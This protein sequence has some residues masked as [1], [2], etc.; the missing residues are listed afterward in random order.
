MTDQPKADKH[1]MAPMSHTEPVAY[2]PGKDPVLDSPHDRE[3][4]VDDFNRVL[5][6]SLALALV[7]VVS[8]YIITS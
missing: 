4:A 3:A 7:F 8:A 2:P 6:Y 5:W 1:P